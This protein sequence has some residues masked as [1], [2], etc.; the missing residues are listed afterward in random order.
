MV[1][2]VANDGRDEDG[3]SKGIRGAFSLIRL[4]TRPSFTGPDDMPRPFT[5][6]SIAFGYSTRVPRITRR[7]L[8]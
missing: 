8:C 7:D 1:E 5:K 3:G 4:C 6:S 2:A